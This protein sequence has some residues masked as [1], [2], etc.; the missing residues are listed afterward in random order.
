MRS[1]FLFF[2]IAQ[3]SLL[4]VSFE[5]D[6]GVELPSWPHH[7]VCERSLGALDL[8]LSCVAAELERGLGSADEPSELQRIAGE[9]AARRI[10]SRALVTVRRR[11]R[12]FVL[13]TQPRPSSQSGCSEA[14]LGASDNSGTSASSGTIAKSCMIKMAKDASPC[15]VA[16]S[17][18]SPN[19]CMT[20]AVD[21]SANPSPRMR[22][23]CHLASSSKA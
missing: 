11:L 18:R 8:V 10:E 6:D 22:A 9:H 23:A 1:L 21:D 16:T 7:A 19:S 4:G 5:N 13:A 17:P 15:C 14:R 12:P 2:F 3:A 20:N